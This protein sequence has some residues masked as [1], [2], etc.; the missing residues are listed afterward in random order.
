M[1]KL[2]LVAA[3]LLLTGAGCIASSRTPVA[4]AP[5]DAGAA[6]TVKKTVPNCNSVIT[7]ADAEKLTGISPLMEIG[8]RPGLGGGTDCEFGKDTGTYVL[9]VELD[10]AN[11]FDQTRAQY[12]D[13]LV[14]VD[15]I[16]EAA[17]RTTGYNLFVKKGGTCVT[18]A[19][20][21]SQQT[22]SSFLTLAQLKGAASF[23]LG[24]M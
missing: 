2:I 10:P 8:N 15:G 22:E 12:S 21:I 1:K 17:F 14:N 7:A 5:L 9:L 16:G 24:K 11:F 6:M 20:F 3:V 23:V 19:T 4:R 18:V 13:S